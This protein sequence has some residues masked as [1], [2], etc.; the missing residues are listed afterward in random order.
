MLTR[1]DPPETR[2]ESYPRLT[3]ELGFITTIILIF[4]LIL[5]RVNG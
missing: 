2:L 5:T 4:V 1:V 3:S